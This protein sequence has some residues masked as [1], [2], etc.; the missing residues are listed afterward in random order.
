MA[1][2][3]TGYVDRELVKKV[4]QLKD[5]DEWDDFI[6]HLLDAVV[7]AIDEFTGRTFFH[8]QSE[9]RW[10]PG[11]GGTRLR[12]D[13]LTSLDTLSVDVDGDGTFE[14]TLGQSD[15]VLTPL[16]T[17]PKEAVQLRGD[18][19]LDAFP[20]WSEA[21]EITASWGWPQIPSDVSHAALM[22]V[23]RWFKRRDVDYVDASTTGNQRILDPDVQ[24]LLKPL[25]KSSGRALG[26]IGG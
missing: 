18:A 1:S 6:D 22:T 9:T 24:T 7:K 23:T 16:N 19:S 10:F 26:V 20:H 17:S 21:V 5:V 8:T 3:T 25:Q 4:L 13:D 11:R 12:I 14:V 15:Y 2:I